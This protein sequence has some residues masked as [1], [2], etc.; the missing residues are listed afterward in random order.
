MPIN[1]APTFI[2]ICWALTIFAACISP[3]LPPITVK[4]C[5]NMYTSLPSIVPY[6]DTTP[7]PDIFFFSI[8]KLTHLCSTKASIST[9]LP[10]S[11]S[12]TILS[13]AVSFPISC[14]LSIAFCPPPNFI[15]SFSSLSSSNLSFGKLL[16]PNQNY[17][18][19]YIIKFD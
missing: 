5:A 3:K 4:S 13:L 10:W 8:P 1:G 9:K 11:N 18:L 12:F 17:I 6:P 14:C 19:F 15:F 16:P 2:A 7:S